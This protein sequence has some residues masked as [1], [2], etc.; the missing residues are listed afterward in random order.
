MPLSIAAVCAANISA[1]FADEGTVALADHA[2]LRTLTI[3]LRS[4]S[5]A[6]FDFSGCASLRDLN[7]TFWKVCLD[8]ILMGSMLPCDA[9]MVAVFP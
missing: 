8:V 5:T 9:Q 1:L 7:L 2:S 4:S 3:E 6:A